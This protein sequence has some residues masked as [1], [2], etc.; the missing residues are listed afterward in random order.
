[1]REYPQSRFVPPADAAD[2]LLVRHGESAPARP[3]QPFP[4]VDGHGDPPLSPAGRAQALLVAARLRRVRLDAVY[5]TTLRRTRETA[6]PLLD[7]LGVEPRVEPGL[8]EVHLGEWEGGLFRKHVSEAHPLA[9]RMYAEERWD[10]IPG[11]ESTE[12]LAGR[13]GDALRRIAAE[14]AGGRVA[15]FTH[16]GVIGQALAMAAA[17]RPFAFVGADNGSISQV[18]IGPDRWAVRRFNDTAHLE[19]DL[20]EAGQPPT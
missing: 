4:L 3:E 12:S 15:V 1:V 10:A 8:R 2:V 19:E 5:V 16:G 6:Q 20:T 7:L 9:L 17:S 14:H 11:A 18:V 13:V